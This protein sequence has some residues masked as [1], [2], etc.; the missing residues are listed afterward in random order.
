MTPFG[1]FGFNLMLAPP[2]AL[3][4]A[5][6]AAAVEGIACESTKGKKKD[7]VP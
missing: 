1:N 2:L 3:P 4:K 7:S 5:T 6:A